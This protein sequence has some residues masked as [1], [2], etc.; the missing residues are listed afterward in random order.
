VLEDIRVGDEQFSR[1]EGV[2]HE[3]AK[4]RMLARFRRA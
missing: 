2:E 4:R 3:E 1:G